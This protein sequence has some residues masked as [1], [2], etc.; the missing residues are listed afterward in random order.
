M[1]KHSLQS[2]VKSGWL[3]T[4]LGFTLIEL[5][6]AIVLGLL[7]SAAVIQVFIIS[8]RTVTTQSSGSD[9]QDNVIFGLQHVEKNLRMVNIGAPDNTTNFNSMMGGVVFTTSIDTASTSANVSNLMNIK[10]NGQQIDTKFFTLG[11]DE[12]GLPATAGKSN[13]DGIKSDQLT[14]Q[15]RVP[16]DM[17]DCEGNE[18]KGPRGVVIGASSSNALT[19]AGGQVVVERYFV[20]EVHSST[21]TRKELGLACDAGVYMPKVIEGKNLN[22]T[23]TNAVTSGNEVAEN[24]LQRFGDDGAVIMNRVDQFQVLLGVRD[25]L[26]NIQYMTIK[27]YKAATVKPNIVSIRLGVLARSSSALAAADAEVNQFNI[28]GTYQTLLADTASP[29]YLRK[30]YESNV[31][32]RNARG[33]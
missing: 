11:G 1:N 3:N 18:V 26:S 6:V 31:L 12:V 9:I 33:L 8:Q 28:L 21:N 23:L 5:M 15:Y 14:I 32:L 2:T 22:V 4:Q 13:I 7:V 29:K 10:R 25:A 20:R 30:V 17:F 27:E 19:P 24:T 16:Q